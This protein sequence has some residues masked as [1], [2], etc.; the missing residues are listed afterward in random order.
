M[1]SGHWIGV[2]PEGD[3]PSV[4]R[5]QPRPPKK[6]DDDDNDNHNNNNGNVGSNNSHKATN[7]MSS[8]VPNAKTPAA[9]ASKPA[10]A[11]NCIQIGDTGSNVK[12]VQELLIGAGVWK[13]NV[14]G[15]TSYLTTDGDFGKTTLAAAKEF[16]GKY[17]LATDGVVGPATMNA[18]CKVNLLGVTDSMLKGGYGRP[19]S[20]HNPKQQLA[21]YEGQE[22]SNGGAVHTFVEFVKGAVSSADNITG[23]IGQGTNGQIQGDS[24]AFYVGKLSTDAAITTYG[25]YETVKGMVETE[26]GGLGIVVSFGNTKTLA[27]VV[28]LTGKGVAEAG[29]G[30]YLASNGLQNTINDAMQ[31]ANGGNSPEAKEPTSPGN[32]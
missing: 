26:T 11:S 32:L 12:A 7:N 19:S 1:G 15:K 13:V 3:P 4:T 31:Y 24:A 14:N 6:D 10:A 17:G 21:D 30:S 27:A 18:L 25:A 5:P 2:N 23:G 29:L 20:K 8:N 28:A 22:T 9:V 16:Q